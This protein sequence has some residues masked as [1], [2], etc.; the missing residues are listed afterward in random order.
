[1]STTKS[2]SP[3]APAI[4]AEGN[5]APALV[6]CAHG[7]R[8][9][10]NAAPAH[11][12]SLARLDCFSTVRWGCLMGKPELA[13]VIDSLPA[14]DILVAPLLMAEGY[15][16][17]VVLPA[18]LAK[19]ARPG[20]ELTLCRPVGSHPRMIELIEDAARE[21][22]SKRGWRVEETA[23]IL[24]AHGTP[25]NAKSSAT[26]RRHAAA[27]AGAGPFPRVET[28]FLEQEPEL[29]EALRNC[30]GQRH[31]VV[32]GLFADRGLHADQDVRRLLCQANSAAAYAGPVGARSEIVELVLDQIAAARRQVA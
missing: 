25:R 32:V 17:G 11:A 22:C 27:L 29:A 28:A 6:L 30:A 13:A 21:T 7:A 18:L 26:A 2:T 3:K 14:P 8:G 24:L 16:A 1:M 10:L 12:E 9:G 15:T 19:L 5:D 20:R 23:L 4:S 31:V